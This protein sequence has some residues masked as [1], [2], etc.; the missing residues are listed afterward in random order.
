MGLNL[1][2]VLVF[3]GVSSLYFPLNRRQSRYYWVSRYDSHIPLIPLFVLP[4]ISFFPFVVLA[5]LA[6]WNT[7][8][9]TAFLSALII[10][11]SLA[12]L[13]WYFYPNGAVRPQI[14]A[15]SWLHKLLLLFYRH[16]KD[17]NAF[18]SSHVFLSLLSS[19]FLALAH[20]AYAVVSWVT[21][22]LITLST[23]FTKQHYVVD[24][25]G[26]VVMVVLAVTLISL[27]G[28]PGFE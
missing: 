22:S 6:L 2:L 21:G 1:F 12:M 8:Y 18:P 23:V 9:E 7:P 10:A 28:F 4:Y 19:Y 15:E 27:A 20:P 24:V 17:T 3:L 26:G 16:D 11:K 13:F 14:A 5:V 25:A